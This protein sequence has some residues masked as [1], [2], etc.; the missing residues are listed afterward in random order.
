METLNKYLEATQHHL[1]VEGERY[2]GGFRAI[3]APRPSVDFLFGMLEGDDNDGTQAQFFFADNPL[4]P[5]AYGETPLQAIEKLD[6][7]LSILYRMVA[8]QGVYKWRAEPQFRLLA[9]YDSEPGEVPQAY[10]V[11][12]ADIVDD[13]GGQSTYFYEGAK[14][15]CSATNKRDLHALVNFEYDGPLALLRE[16]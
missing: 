15:I 3:V 13:L 4:F 16:V 12:W 8:D 2:G 1:G 14:D 9:N 5:A 11:A 10:P 7:K 6:A